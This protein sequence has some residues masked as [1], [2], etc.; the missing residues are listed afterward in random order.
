MNYQFKT[1]NMKKLLL[2]ITAIA[3][4][5]VGCSSD[6]DGTVTPPPTTGG[7]V[8]VK[9]GIITANETWTAD[10]MYV[11]NGKV[12]IN[13]GV[14]LTIQPGT[15]VKGE[16][17]QDTQASALIVDQG[18]KLIADGTANAPIVFTSILDNI[19]IGQTAGTN[20]TIDDIGLW[21]GVIVLG[22]A[23]IS[24]DGDLTTN[25]IEG[26]PANEP[27]GQYGGNIPNDNSGIIRYVSIRHGGI[28]IGQDNEINGLTLGGVGSGTIVSHVEVVAN[29]DDAFEWF[30]GTVNSSNLLAWAQQDDGL[31]ID[32]SYSGTINNAVV[33]QSANS[34]RAMEIDGP[35]GSSA[36]YASF[37]MTNV[38]LIGDPTNLFYADLRDGARGTMNNVLA[39]G[40]GPNAKIRFNDAESQS[41]FATGIIG[42]SNWQLVLPAGVTLDSLLVNAPAGSETNFTANASAVTSAAQ[43]TVGANLSV[44]G[45][46]YAAAKGAL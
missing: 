9:T 32:Q 2:A 43:A 33:I 39:I 24:V 19:E 11:L 29:Q 15:I 27:F 13:E 8:I 22:R 14:T 16:Q 41:N 38:T 36:T 30:G 45:W 4:F 3:F 12:V 40:F 7:E 46:T 44:F 37:T 26:I 1:K 34:D 18:G 20:L 31:D 35:E 21:G 25:Q 23:P 10:N 17:G 28:T 5:T 6:D 42:F